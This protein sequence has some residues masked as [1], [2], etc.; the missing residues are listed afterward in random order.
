MPATDRAK[1]FARFTALAARIGL[2]H[3]ESVFDVLYAHYTGPD[4]HYHDIGH[5]AASLIELDGVRHLARDPAAIELAIWFHDCIYDGRRLDNEERSAAVARQALHQ[6]GASD[7]LIDTVC[8]LILA[9]KHTTVPATP[10]EQLLCDIDLVPLGASNEIF[11]SNGQ[12]I[13]QEYAH[14]DD[15]TYTTGRAQILEGFLARPHIFSTDTYAQ[16]YERQARSNLS[17]AIKAKSNGV[18]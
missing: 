2:H 8:Q 6:M 7:D 14:L 13:R 9:T 17:R 10:D 5:I 4:R 3:A 15:H 18:R 12:L 1:L 16:R 11:D